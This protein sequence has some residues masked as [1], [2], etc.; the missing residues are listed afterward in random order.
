MTTGDKV[1]EGPTDVSTHHHSELVAEM[2]L[3]EKAA[4][5]TGASGWTTVGVPRLGVEPLFLA[6][7]PHGVRRVPDV[8]S[9][10]MVTAIPAT[11]F[12]TATSLASSWDP[13]LLRAVA[14]AIGSEAR[15]LGVD[16]VLGPGVNMKRSPLCG[17]NFEYFSEDPFLAGELAVAY[18]E[19]VQS[20]GVGACLKHFAVNNQE[21]RRFS[22]DARLDE[23]TLREIYLPAFEAA[24]RRAKP[25]AVMCSY[26]SVNG[27][28]AS[29]NSYLLTDILRDEWGFDGVVMSDWGAVRNRVLAAAAG[30][31]LEMPGP[32]AHRVAGVVGAVQDGRL[33]VEVV[34]AAS[35]RIV[36]L[37]ERVAGR[38][39]TVPFEPE[40]HHT[41]ARRAAAE[42][43]VL[44]KN[45]GTLP[46]RDCARI[47]VIG[48]G[49]RVPHYQGTGSSHITPTQLDEPLTEL[50]RQAGSAVVE[51]AE[52]HAEGPEE[53]QD[54]MDEA[55]GTAAAADVA[56][57][58][59]T[60][61]DWKEAEGADRMDIHLPA[62]QVKLIKAVAAAQPRTV[63]VLNNG[64]AI[65][66]GDWVDGVAAVLDA[67]LMGQ[68]GGS[69]LADVIFGHVNPSG[70]LAETFPVRLE[71]TPAYLNFP[72]DR[73][74]VRYGEGL[75]IGYRWY[76][77]RDIPVQFPFGH[78]LSYTTFEYSDLRV[79]EQVRDA[80]HGL[81]LS[82]LVTNS[83]ALAGKEVVQVYV[84]PRASRLARP[85]RELKGFAKV[86]V[87][88]GEARS[89]SI[90]LDAR[91]FEY[92]DPGAGWVCDAG[93]YELL[94]G[95]SSRDIR[96]SATVQVLG[97]GRSLD[98]GRYST[99]GDWLN[100]PVGRPLALKLLEELGPPLAR[101]LGSEPDDPERL[102]A[103][104]LVFLESMPV[105]TVAEFAGAPS[106]FGTNGDEVVETLLD[107]VA[108]AGQVSDSSDK[109]HDERS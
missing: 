105:P 52:G 100:D 10:D 60:L 23:R 55:I 44:L 103:L 88:P 7:G 18:I 43:M 98:L 29:E 53:R 30:L 6:D 51:Y 67:W 61:P 87:D 14:G 5:L 79:S 20:R 21:T 17:R 109:A 32:R 16:M 96:L 71:D 83:G 46:L 41:L 22:V 31:D 37:G 66:V 15:A 73:D 93:E 45:D 97:P 27:Q 104:A 78:G 2:R 69:A 92:F 102:S 49:A 54:L 74:V 1:G 89:V 86:A 95:S 42:G 25:W 40:E 56:V 24:V 91:A 82:L 77:A 81:T 108:S 85:D 58:F 48:R 84:R 59:A 8:D 106:T 33:P 80:R 72:G 19:G 34:D 12:P 90:T 26:N 94:V 107:L 3:E 99:L 62:Q 68:A 50:S 101:A 39:T 4:L 47:A 11:C 75:F 70:K 65:A 57:V 36:R 9:L 63:V 28:M 13:D 64:S 38:A 35:E 76:D